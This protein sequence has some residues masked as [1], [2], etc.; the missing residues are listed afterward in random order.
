MPAVSAWRLGVVAA[1]IAFGIAVA[2]GHPYPDYKVQD[3]FSDRYLISW[4]FLP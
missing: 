3:E 2:L 4:T 1:Y